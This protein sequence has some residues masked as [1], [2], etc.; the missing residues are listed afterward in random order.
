MKRLLIALLFAL[1]FHGCG[2]GGT[3]V[4]NPPGPQVPNAGA[5]GVEDQSGASPSPTPSPEA[6]LQFDDTGDEN[7]IALNPE[8]T[9][10]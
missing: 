2:M 4:G 6:T 1:A 8:E 9:D 3:E 5:P 10:L 7:Q